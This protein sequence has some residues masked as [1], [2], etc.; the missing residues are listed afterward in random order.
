MN[1]QRERRQLELFGVEQQLKPLPTPMWI[2]STA[3]WTAKLLLMT[4][5][6]AVAMNIAAGVIDRE[7]MMQR[8]QKTLMEKLK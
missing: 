5:F 4:A 8:Q 1:K 7:I 6:A 3:V 2:Q